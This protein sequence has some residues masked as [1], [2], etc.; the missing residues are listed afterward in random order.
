MFSLLYY[1]GI[2]P[3][4]SLNVNS[5]LQ[6]NFNFFLQILDIFAIYCRG[7][8]RSSVTA[9]TTLYQ[10]TATGRPYIL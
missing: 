6:E 5:F 10:R 8:H 4:D 3:R 7:E 1:P 9:V 2:L